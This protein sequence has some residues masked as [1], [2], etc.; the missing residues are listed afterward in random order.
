MNTKNRPI[1][2]VIL[3]A[4]VILGSFQG[5]AQNTKD[6]PPPPPHPESDIAIPP[7]PPP[8]PGV[9]VPP[10][11]PAQILPDLSDEQKAALKI[12]DLGN[13]KV[14]STLQNHLREKEAHL[15]VLLTGDEPDQK[16]IEQTIQEIGGVYTKILKQQVSHDREIR[17]IL[18]P[19][20]KIVFDSH[21]K[22]FLR[23]P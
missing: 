15:V 17:N 12:S 9:P 3:T 21:P 2:G 4:L 23:L 11:P 16:G 20:Q 13:L 14:I 1:T 19:E 8:P 22:P 7:P 6:M 10:P 18:T 5:I